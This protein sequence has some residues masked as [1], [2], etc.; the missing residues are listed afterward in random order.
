MLSA[1]RHPASGVG[2]EQGQRE[3][4]VGQ[5]MSRLITRNV[6]IMALTLVVCLPLLRMWGRGGEAV[7]AQG[8]H[9]VMAVYAQQGLA[10]TP[11]MDTCCC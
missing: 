11:V 9:T 10:L 4:R 5:K 1:A 7:L 2:V 8:L 3:M 6:I